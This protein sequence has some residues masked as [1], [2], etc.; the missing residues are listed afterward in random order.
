MYFPLNVY[1]YS[2]QY[3]NMH[4]YENVVLNNFIYAACIL[5]KVS[6]EENIFSKNEIYLL[7]SAKGI[8]NIVLTL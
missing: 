8:C 5:R 6:D 3:D 2:F 4:G 1:G 7:T